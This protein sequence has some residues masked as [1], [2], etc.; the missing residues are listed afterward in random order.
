MWAGLP[1]VGAEVA[2]GLADLTGAG[3]PTVAVFVDMLSVLSWWLRKG[4]ENRG[5]FPKAF[6]VPG[7]H[8]RP[9]ERGKMTASTARIPCNTNTPSWSVQEMVFFCQFWSESC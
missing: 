3:L 9:S 6:F 7:V 1:D 2:F 8:M 4:S 5:S